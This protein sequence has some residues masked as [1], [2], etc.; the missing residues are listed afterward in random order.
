MKGKIISF[1]KLIYVEKP[2]KFYFSPVYCNMI[3]N[4]K[5]GMKKFWP[6]F[7]LELS[8]YV[9]YV[10]F[11]FYFSCRF[12]VSTCRIL[13]LNRTCQNN[14]LIVLILTTLENFLNFKFFLPFERS[15][16]LEDVNSKTMFTF[17]RKANC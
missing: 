11:L 12:E 7:I 2:P 10:V 15:G 4:R 8:T 14:F 17:S 6:L 3:I 1:Y 5:K 9:L 16:N 13:K